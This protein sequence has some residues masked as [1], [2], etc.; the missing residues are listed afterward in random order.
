M[1]RPHPRGRAGGKHHHLTCWTRWR[2]AKRMHRRG[3]VHGGFT[4]GSP[5]FDGGNHRIDLQAY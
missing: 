5:V 4:L 1:Y 3:L 2:Q